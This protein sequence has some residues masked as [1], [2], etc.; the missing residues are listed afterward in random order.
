MALDLQ[1]PEIPLL[2]AFGVLDL[3]QVVAAGLPTTIQLEGA[4]RSEYVHAN[5][6]GTASDG[7]THDLLVPAIQVQDPNELV[8]ILIPVSLLQATD[9]G[10]ALFSYSVQPTRDYQPGYPESRR[11]A[12]LVGKRHFPGAGL[13]V[14]VVKEAHREQLNRDDVPDAGAS[15]CICAWQAMRAG[16]K[17][18]LVWQGYNSACVPKQPYSYDIT[19]TEADVGLSVQMTVPRAQLATISGGH[20]QLSYYID[21]VN[22]TGRTL[23]PAQRFSID[24][25]ATD[26]LPALTIA[27]Q[28]GDTLDPALITTGLTFCAERYPQLREGDTLAVYATDPLAETAEPI[29]S[30]RLDRSSVDSGLLQ[31]KTDGDWLWDYLGRDILFSYHVARPGLA[32]GSETLRLPVRAAMNLPAPVVAGASGAGQS[33]GEFKALSTGDGVKVWVPSAAVYPSNAAIEMH[34]EGF[35]DSG[36]YVSRSPT[37]DIPPAYIIVPEVVAPNM[38]K[39]VRVFYR[40]LV[41]NEPTRQSAIFSVKVLPIPEI[42]YPTL[43]CEEARNGALSR[44]SLPNNY[45]TQTIAKWPLVALGQRFDVIATGT[46]NGGG[47]TRNYLL[48][49]TSV[50]AAQVDSGVTARLDKTWLMTLQLGTDV[51][52]TFRVTADEG[53][54]YVNFPRVYIKITA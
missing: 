48:Q 50:T 2:D 4:N 6:L 5:W 11:A 34:W 17:V 3:D 1:A 43:V 12:V 10:H 30:V 18:T 24:P 47:T 32:L 23:A 54:S 27:E 35:G 49:N 29:A 7:T 20:A 22:D 38:G 42:Y 15:V 52:F 13:N 39:G 26:R 51:T 36:S 21:Y 16:D 44:G 19:V 31:C 14:A 41:P 9:Q 46:L 8:A 33:E 40:V 25:A 45:S 53:E 37:G 28:S